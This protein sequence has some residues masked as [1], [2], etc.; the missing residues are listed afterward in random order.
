MSSGILDSA[1]HVLATV[2]LI[3]RIAGTSFEPVVVESLKISTRE[4]MLRVCGSI[5]AANANLQETWR[6]A[7][8]QEKSQLKY[9]YAALVA[10]LV[11][12]RL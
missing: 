9:G 12:C 6:E 2:F 1:S 8:G 7:K 11:F 4:H 5:E 3:Y 10:R